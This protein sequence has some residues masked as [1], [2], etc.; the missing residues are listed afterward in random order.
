MTYVIQTMG[1]VPVED[2]SLSG[3]LTIPNWG[4]GSSAV[5]YGAGSNHLSELN[6]LMDKVLHQHGSGTL[7][8]DLLTKM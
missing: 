2:A 3:Q 4:R 6:H 7:L 5:A 1:T 8:F